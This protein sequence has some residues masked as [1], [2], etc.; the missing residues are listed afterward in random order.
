[1]EKSAYDNHGERVVIGQRLMQSASDLFLGWT[2]GQGG[3]HFYIRQLHDVKVKP[4]VEFYDPPTMNIYAEYCGWVLARAHARSGSPKQ[5]SEYLGSSDRFDQSIA[6]FA[7]AYGD[8]NEQDY[9]EFVQ[10]VKKRRLPA[11]T[12][13]N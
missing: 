5:I 13:R 10:A 3:R 2:Y 11:V 4:M 9:R 8:Q 7:E 1:L 6:D 12:E